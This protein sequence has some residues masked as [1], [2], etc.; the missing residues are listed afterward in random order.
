MPES[1][2]RKGFDDL[3]RGI[4]AAHAAHA[5]LWLDRYINSQTRDDA[6][7]RTSHVREVASVPVPPSYNSFFQRWKTGLE[8]YGARTDCEA[9]AKGRVVV[10]LGAESVLETSIALHHT[11]GVPYIPGSALKGLAA[12][13][14]H[15]H[16]GGRW[17]KG[18]DAHG[19]MFGD[20]SSAGY[21]TFFDAL[22][23]P[24]TGKG[25]NGSPL[26]PDVMAIHHKDYYGGSNVA[27]A[28]WDDPTIVPFLTATGS[29]LVPLSGP[30]T[31]VNVAYGILALALD[32]MGIGAKTSSG[33]GRMTLDGLEQARKRLKRMNSTSE[34]TVPSSSAI[35]VGTLVTGQRARNFERIEWE[36]QR[37]KVVRIQVN[38]LEQYTLPAGVS[39]EFFATDEITG[40][41][42]RGEVTDIDES[43][44]KRLRILLTKVRKPSGGA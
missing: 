40:G 1:S 44:P 30:K 38:K 34:S 9:T 11:Y 42:F 17:S 37:L 24:D 26:A 35:S 33:Y 41:G 21:I 15:R 39:I 32:E 19:V 22:Y 36:G 5:G 12:A 20:T 6:G 2:R 25:T 14:A 31:W 16:I 8:T 10:G 4:L 13:Y 23:V 29:Y 7:A 43:I 3:L 18:G 27:P 28:D